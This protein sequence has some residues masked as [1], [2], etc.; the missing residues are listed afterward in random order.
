M[1]VHKGFGQGWIRLAEL[2][3][4][5]SQFKNYTSDGEEILIVEPSED[6]SET[7][8]IRLS[9]PKPDALQNAIKAIGQ[10]PFDINTQTLKRGDSV[11]F[12]A[13]PPSR[14]KSQIIRLTQE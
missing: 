9:P 7:T 10:T 1:E 11:I 6:G 5:P 2:S 12:E 3:S 14:D 13:M 4:R 8:I